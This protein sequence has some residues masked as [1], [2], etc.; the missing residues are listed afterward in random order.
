MDWVRPPANVEAGRW[1][2]PQGSSGSIL[3]GWASAP[4]P[5]TVVTLGTVVAG[6]GVEQGAVSQDPPPVSHQRDVAWVGQ[7]LL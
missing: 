3:P 6:K 4:L 5:E 1:S 2:V 7:P